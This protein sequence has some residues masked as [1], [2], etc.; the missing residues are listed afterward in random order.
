MKATQKVLDWIKENF[1]E[2]IRAIHELKTY[3]DEFDAILAGEKHHD[4]RKS[5]RDFQTGDWILYREW[6]PWRDEYTGRQMFREVT[7]ID[8]PRS[9]GLPDDLCV[10]SIR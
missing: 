10:L 4:V 2:E 5:D 3:P 1:S 6:I 8:A 7:F 9:W